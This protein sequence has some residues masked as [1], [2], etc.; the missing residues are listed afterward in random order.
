MLINIL[1]IIGT[2]W[3]LTS[4]NK[5]SA[6][7]NFNIEQHEMKKSLHSFFAFKTGWIIFSRKTLFV[8]K[9]FTYFKGLVSFPDNFWPNL[10][11][12]PWQNE[13]DSGLAVEIRHVTRINAWTDL[14]FPGYVSE[15]KSHPIRRR[16]FLFWALACNYC[17]FYHVA[18]IFPGHVHHRADW[19]TAAYS[20]PTVIVSV[21]WYEYN[22]QKRP[23]K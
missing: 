19:R 18:G 13:C 17:S 5:L 11:L 16:F 15:N 14:T 7:F 23:Q 21:K 6:T 3:D 8:L 1:F 10:P 12:L 9:V 20:G 22:W 4:F 2:F